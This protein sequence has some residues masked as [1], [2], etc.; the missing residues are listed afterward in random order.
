MAE[1]D[2]TQLGV[3]GFADISGFWWLKPSAQGFH[4]PTWVVSAEA[5]VCFLF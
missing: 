5:M 4:L 3:V 1:S 2:V